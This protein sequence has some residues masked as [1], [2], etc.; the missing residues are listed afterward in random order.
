MGRSRGYWWS[1]DGTR[2]LV[3]RV[4]ETSV[5]RWHIAD[6]A[7][8]DKQPVEVGYPAAGTQNADVSLFIADLAKP[9]A[10]GVGEGDGLTSVGWDRAAFPY[11]VT[12]AWGDHLLIVVQSRD[13]K[14]MRLINAATGA[15]LREDSD[16]H[17]TDIIAGLPA[18]LGNGDIVWSGISEDTRGLVISPAAELATAGPLTPPGL[19]VLAVL[20]ADGD[21]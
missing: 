12:A 4:D 3:A 13:Q 17:W 10:E 19:Q 18:Q 11:L 8:P 1:P 14:T 2:L 21:D 6:P 9:G 20:D 5:K 16:P 15:V 7:N